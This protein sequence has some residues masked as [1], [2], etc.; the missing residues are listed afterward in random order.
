MAS[1]T[2]DKDG[3][4]EHKD[5]YAS[6][7]C[8]GGIDQLTKDTTNL[9]LSSQGPTNGQKAA[10]ERLMQASVPSA[11]NETLP[12]T[13]QLMVLINQAKANGGI[14]RT[15]FGH[16]D[17]AARGSHQIARGGYFQTREVGGLGVAKYPLL[18]TE[19]TELSARSYKAL[20]NELRILSHPPLMNHGNIVKINTIGWTRLDPSGA[21]WMPM[22]FLELAELGTLTKYLSEKRL[23]VDSKLRIAQDVGYGLQAL[24][25][26][27]ITHGDLKLDNVLMFKEN[28]GKVRAKL[29]DFGCSYITK[30]NEDKEAKVEISAGTMPWNSPELNQEVP[31]S[32]LP[33]VDTYSFGLLV[34]RVFLNGRDPFEGQEYGDIDR[35]KAQDLIISDASLS[36]EDEYNKNMLL[37]GALSSSDRIHL[38]MRGVAMPKRCFRHTMSSMIQNRN[39]DAAMNSLSFKK[40]YGY[41]SMQETYS[42]IQELF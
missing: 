6:Y 12:I 24:H 22:I 40:I 30:D 41:G 35:R 8:D 29:C 25:A 18:A 28:D 10:P 20:A 19:S 23:E 13:Y 37:R 16:H 36:L 11:T 34:W 32:W 3:S 26:C 9:T 17:F 38:Y 42:P 31:V 15:D 2:N 5:G 4:A 7:T 33:N 21:A 39:L 27:G 1:F 14:V